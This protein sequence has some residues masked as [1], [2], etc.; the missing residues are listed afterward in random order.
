MSLRL[1]FMR[2]CLLF[3]LSLCTAIVLSG[4][5][6]PSGAS[7]DGVT[8]PQLISKGPKWK[9]VEQLRQFA[10]QG[11][12]QACFELGDRL[13]NGDG[14]PAD[15]A[16]ARTW[17]ERAARGGVAEAMFRL[18][19]MSFDGVGGPK[20]IELALDYYAQAAV[21]GVPEAQHNVGA[22]LVSGRGVKR[23]WPEG[24][25]WL[26]VAEKNGAAS[27]AVARTRE[28]LAKRPADIAAAEK[29][30]EEILA[31]LADPAKRASAAPRFSTAGAPPATPPP[32]SEP[33]PDAP[34][35][36]K[37]D[38]GPGFT[39]PKPQIDLPKN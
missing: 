17:L 9:T 32:I 34:G 23:D 39:P 5:K 29:R 31:A 33:K 18:G 21:L 1:L 15:P 26:I 3:P 24:L 6:P 4:A 37:V 19:K 16:A 10:A 11:D 2:A 35:K 12:P 36:V 30:A 27:D 14:M 7:V 20:S 22:I 28:H 13:V 38:L 25:A 8:P